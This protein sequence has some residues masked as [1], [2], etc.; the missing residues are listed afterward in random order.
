MYPEIYPLKLVIKKSFYSCW[1]C[2]TGPVNGTGLSWRLSGPY[3]AEPHRCADPSPQPQVRIKLLS[4]MGIPKQQPQCLQIPPS[5]SSMAMMLQQPSLSKIKI[6]CRFAQTQPGH[7]LVVP[8]NNCARPPVGTKPP[9][10]AW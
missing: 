2:K 5:P 9:S 4:A 3:L 7:S 6:V 8:G 10:P 1:T